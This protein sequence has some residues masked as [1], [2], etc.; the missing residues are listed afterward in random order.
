[1]H[2]LTLSHLNGALSTGPTTRRRQICEKISISQDMFTHFLYGH[3]PAQH[4][5]I[6]LINLTCNS[7]Q[8]TIQQLQH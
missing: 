5:A 2:K 6:K 7:G 4:K 3:H 1:L 8:H